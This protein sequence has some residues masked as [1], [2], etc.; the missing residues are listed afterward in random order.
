MSEAKTRPTDQDVETFLQGI[1]DAQQRQDCHTILDLMREVTGAEPKMWGTS[2]V[3]FGSYHYRYATGREGDAPLTGFSP[4]KQNLTLYLSYGFEQHAELMERLGKHK[5][6][7]ACLY[8][9]R[10]SNVD[11]AALRELIQQSVAEVV[12]MNAPAG[13][14][15]AS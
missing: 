15:K 2:I 10:L 9:K 8:I 1:E 3:G 14:T 7:K 5:V 6:G 12:R 11:R 4:R 13:A